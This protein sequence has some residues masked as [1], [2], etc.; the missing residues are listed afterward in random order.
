MVVNDVTWV[1]F[2]ALFFNA[3]GTVR[4]WDPDD[5]CM[6][7][8]ILLTASGIAHR[9]ARQRRKLGQLVGRRR[10]R[11][12]LALPLD[13]L[14]YLLAAGSTPPA[15]RP[16]VGAGA[17]RATPATRRPRAS[18]CSAGPRWPAPWLVGF[19]VSVGSL[20]LFVGGRGE[21]ADLGFHAI[22]IL[23]SYPLD[24]FGGATKVVLFTAVPAAFVTGLPA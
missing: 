20:T 16:D 12:A 24:M 1:M 8:A 9:P 14:P 7:F 5:V 11:R 22:L 4:G 23:A 6:L 15:R 2:W 19:L 3:V 10:D 13:P 17:V 21:Q 18:P